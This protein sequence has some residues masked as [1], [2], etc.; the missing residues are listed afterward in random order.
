MRAAFTR[1]T[2]YHC[3]LTQYHLVPAHF[4]H[5]LLFCYH[6]T[7]C[8]HYTF[9]HRFSFWVSG[10]Q[11]THTHLPHAA[12]CLLRAPYVMPFYAVLLLPPLQHH[13]RAAP[14]ALWFGCLRITLLRCCASPYAFVSH[15]ADFFYLVLLLHCARIFAMHMHS[16]PRHLHSAATSAYFSTLFSA[17]IPL[18]YTT[19]PSVLFFF[20]TYYTWRLPFYALPAHAV[21]RSTKI[22]RFHTYWF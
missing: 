3:K 2:T 21:L 9:S 8:H 14:C 18:S 11:Y 4:S 16:I 10:L 12:R 5:I 7:C 19:L 15:I 6:T 1:F 17:C 13:A 20:F 22:S